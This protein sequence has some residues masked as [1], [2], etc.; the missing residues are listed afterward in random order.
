MPSMF[1]IDAPGGAGWQGH[2]FSGWSPSPLALLPFLLLFLFF[3]HYTK[4]RH[5]INEEVQPKQRS[6]VVQWLSAQLQ[7]KRLVVQILPEMP[8]QKDLVIC[9]HRDDSL[10][11]PMGKFHPVI[12]H[13]QNQLD[14]TQQ[15]QHFK[16]QQQ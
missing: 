9:S 12:W 3:A 7:T 2:G 15:Q 8:Q 14:G 5:G 6:L 11:N 1:M 10:E 16:R 13:F 4:C